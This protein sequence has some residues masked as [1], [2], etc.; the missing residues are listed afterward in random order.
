MYILDMRPPIVE[1]FFFNGYMY[2]HCPIAPA[3]I[4]AGVAGDGSVA[5]V[6]ILF[7]IIN[8]DVMFGVNELLPV[9]ITTTP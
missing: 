4:S 1:M 7:E 6:G 9:L 5:N 8:L 2:P 3:G